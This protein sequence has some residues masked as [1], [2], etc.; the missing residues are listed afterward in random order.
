MAVG[1][2]LDEDPY[3]P[4]Y[5]LS[6]DQQNT[7]RQ[8]LDRFL[9][10]EFAKYMRENGHQNFARTEPSRR[11]LREMQRDRD[12]EA[13]S[14][15]GTSSENEGAREQYEEELDYQ[16]LSLARADAVMTSV[17][18]AH[19]AGGGR[20]E[21]YLAAC[22]AMQAHAE[23]RGEPWDL[24]Q[25]GVPLTEE[26]HPSLVRRL[27]RDAKSLSQVLG[28]MHDNLLSSMGKAAQESFSEKTGFGRRTRSG[29]QVSELEEKG[30]KAL[31]QRLDRL[32]Y[33]QTHDR[34]EQDAKCLFGP[35]EAATQALSI[36]L[37]S[38]KLD[39]DDESAAVRGPSILPPIS[40][41]VPVQ[42]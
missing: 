25:D 7:A 31:K 24:P 34:A 3:D 8:R 2:D 22:K 26:S 23:E 13:S 32:S 33:Q 29:R 1:S 12:R 30:V 21:I 6:L 27:S 41:Y 37:F 40:V 4:L 11:K 15:Y 42:H 39:Y 5:E 35:D 10:L 18:S 36:E 9:D 16:L 14:R 20:E 19:S 17:A 38:T 28:F